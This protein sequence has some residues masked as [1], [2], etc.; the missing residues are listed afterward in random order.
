MEE[1]REPEAT[2]E[3]RVDTTTETSQEAEPAEETTAGAEKREGKAEEEEERDEEGLWDKVRKGVVEGY[4]F[5]A[6]KTDLYTKVGSRRLAIVGINRKIDRAY[7]D[8]GEKVYNLLA[9]SGECVG[10]TMN[11]G[12]GTSI[13]VLE[14]IAHL[15]QL[16]G[17]AASIQHVDPA[18]GDARH[19]LAD[20]SR[21]QQLLG[22]SSAT[23]LGDGLAASV[24][25]IL[26][27][28][29]S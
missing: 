13:T 12:G 25:S 26:E 28:Y 1:K 8:L 11:I 16:T 2:E 24:Q 14:L 4:Q 17:K 5:A 27:F 3:E 19:T 22:W 15:E 18:K 23:E 6:D 21:A 10:E 7:S 29:Y 20:N 9:A